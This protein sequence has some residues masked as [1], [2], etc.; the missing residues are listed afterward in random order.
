MKENQTAIYYALGDNEAAIKAS[1]HLEGYRARDV[2]VLYLADPVD[3]FWVRTALGYQGK[4]FKSI[5]QGSDDLE[6]IKPAN[7]TDDGN[8]KKKE[9]NAAKLA[10]L[11]TFLKESLGKDV[12]DVR[13]SSRLAESPVCLVAS[14]GALDMQLQK[15]LKDQPDAAIN[16]APVL[17]INPAHPMIQ[18]LAQHVETGKDKALAEQIAVALHGQARI[19]DGEQPVDPAKFATAIA[20]F[21]NRALE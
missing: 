1:P 11:Y 15:I 7:P 18:K 21:M 9:E 19:L 17:E 5:T 16:P 8:S 13:A 14:D 12:S 3:A 6:T 10:T 20:T 4:P 2:E